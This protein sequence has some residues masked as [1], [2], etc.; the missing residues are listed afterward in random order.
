MTL[1]NYMIEMVSRSDPKVMDLAKEFSDLKKVRMVSIRDLVAQAGSLKKGLAKLASYRYRDLPKGGAK[2]PFEDKMNAF[3]AEARVRLEQ[4]QAKIEEAKEAWTATAG[5]FLEDLEEYESVWD[6]VATPVSAMVSPGEGNNTDDSNRAKQP[7]ALFASMDL[8]MSY[9][10]EAVLQN[11]KRADDEAR[12][13]KRAKEAEEKA[14]KLAEKGVV[15]AE[16]QGGAG[17]A[18]EPPAVRRHRRRASS[19]EKR[20]S[21]SDVVM[22][23]ALKARM[24]PKLG[25]GEEFEEETGEGKAKFKRGTKGLVCAGCGMMGAKCECKF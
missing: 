20:M 21:F 22:Q 5:Y 25:L 3:I 2:P 19:A 6:S 11:K 18:L 17:G 10:A 23:A 16:D 1:M 14:K 7:E 13:I 15:V 9:V 8:L 4:L 24:N 12:K